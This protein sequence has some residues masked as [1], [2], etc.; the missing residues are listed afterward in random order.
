MLVMTVV[1]SH[2]IEIEIGLTG[3]PCILIF[4]GR[5][6]LEWVCVRLTYFSQFYSEIGN[7]LST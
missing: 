4:L 5:K 6:A 2:S 1:Q 7:K 3:K